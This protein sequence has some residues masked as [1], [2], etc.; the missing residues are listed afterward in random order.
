MCVCVCVCVLLVIDTGGSCLTLPAEIF[1]DFKSWWQP[2]SGDGTQGVDLSTLPV[3]KFSMADVYA[4]VDSYGNSNSNGNDDGEELV[5]YLSNLVVNQSDITMGMKRQSD[6]ILL[7]SSAT[8]STLAVCVLRG[9]SVTGPNGQM[10]TPHISLG[11][12]VLRSLYFAADY[13]SGGLGLANKLNSSTSLSSN[14]NTCPFC[15]SAVQCIGQQTI[16]DYSNNCMD[17]DCSS[18]FFVTLD[19]STHRY[20]YLSF[21]VYFYHIYSLL[22]LFFVLWMTLLY[23][24]NSAA[25]TVLD[26]PSLESCWYPC[27]LPLTCQLPSFMHAL[28]VCL[29]R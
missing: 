3:L 16:D 4:P 20:A 5:I 2:L 12:L 9:Q 27:S 6:V 13:T 26:I 24:L 29:Y 22:D 21:I 23:V 1:D 18:Y 10:R 8:E 15:R 17:P 11:S 25:S 7:S 28:R 19:E 14:T